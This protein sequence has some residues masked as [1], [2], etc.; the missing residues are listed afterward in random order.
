MDHFPRSVRPKAPPIKT[1][2]IKTKLVPFILQSF[3]WDGRGK[4]IEPFVGSGAVV[5]N[6]APRQALIADTNKHI[7]HFYKS[8]QDCTLTPADARDY[9]EVEGAKLEALGADHFYAVRKRFNETGSPLDFLF[10]SRACFNGVMRF[11]KKGGFNVPFCKKDGRFAKAYVTKICNQIAWVAGIIRR[12]DWTFVCQDWRMTLAQA[13][14]GDFTYVDPP[15][16][17]RHTGYFDSWSDESAVELATALKALPCGFA[18]SMWQSNKYRH[19]DHI[20]ECFPSY[21][22]V[23]H[24]HFYHVG[25]TESLR[26]EVKEALVVHPANA[27][28]QIPQLVTAKPSQ[29]AFL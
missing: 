7:I 13:E 22:A 4:W 23:T 2:G 5:F 26:N 18:Y 11:N 14:E 12:G 29:L 17:G 21:P 10:L 15:Y 24:S 27:I 3:S 16:V 6:A 28:E 20:Q 9:L 25:S 19:N 1:Q 8:I